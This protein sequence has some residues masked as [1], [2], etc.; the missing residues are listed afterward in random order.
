MELALLLVLLVAVELALTFYLLGRI[1]S[2]KFTLNGLVDRVAI[3]DDGLDQVM[4]EVKGNN[5]ETLGM[6]DTLAGAAADKTATTHDVDI[7]SLVSSATPDDIQ[8]AASILRAL[9][10]KVDDEG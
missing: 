1:K 7:A 10:V 2:Y 6:G 8:Q 5:S 4:N 3:I 9:G